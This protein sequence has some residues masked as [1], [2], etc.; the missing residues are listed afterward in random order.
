MSKLPSAFSFTFFIDDFSF[1]TVRTHQ[2]EFLHRLFYHPSSIT[3]HPSSITRLQSVLDDY[4]RLAW[5][6]KP[7][8]MGWEYEWD[9]KEH[10]GLKPT[11]FSFR[12]YDE[13][14]RRLADYQRISDEVERLSEELRMKNEE[15]AA[16]FFELLQ[17]PVQGACQMN[18]KF[19]MAQL[20][21]ELAAEGRLSEA[22]WAARQMEQAYD[23]I[24]ALNLRYNKQLN[25]KW[26]GM[27]ALS[28][29]F[30]PTC[31]YYQ[32]PVVQRFDDAA[33]RIEN[34]EL[35]V[36]NYDMSQGSVSATKGNHN[37]QFSTLNSP[38]DER[39]PFL[40]PFGSKRPEVERTE[41]Q[42]CH[43]VDLTRPVR[44]NHVTM[45][46][47]L[48]YDGT[49]VQFGDPTIQPIDGAPADVIYDFPATSADSVDVVLYTVPFWPL[50]EG[51]TNSVGVS[52]DQSAV[53]VFENHFQE[54]SRSWKDQVMRNGAV[55]R[56]RFAIDPSRSRHQL[57]L[58]GDPGQMVQRVII[59]WGGLQASY[60]GPQIN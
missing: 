33:L 5:S 26:D 7:E 46:R 25:G 18:R 27:M 38:F 50:Y 8:F 11:E 2:A 12:H 59:D 48:G 21:Q 29:S 3:H 34:G 60:I 43:V 54:Y 44:A 51:K 56:L 22:N 58:V 10:T 52:I 6:R 16:A 19:L 23:S 4:Y 49:V 1:E 41:S 42:G 13:A 37:S 24:N 15:Y 45:V 30:T 32:K 55:C 40:R 31:Q 35:R 17:F 14:Q 9:D 53:Q 20:N 57:R 39:S 28:T 47:G 36:E